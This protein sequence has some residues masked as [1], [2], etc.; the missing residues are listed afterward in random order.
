MQYVPETTT[1]SSKYFSTPS[2]HVPFMVT[3]QELIG[4]RTLK[5]YFSFVSKFK[6]SG[7]YILSWE[8]IIELSVHK[9]AADG[10]GRYFVCYV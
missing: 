2:L 4:K 8:D 9:S 6:L 5:I 1:E 7:R 10:S 3:V